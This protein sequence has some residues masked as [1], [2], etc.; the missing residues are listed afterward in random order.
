MRIARQRLLH[1]QGQAVHAAPHIGVA[2][3]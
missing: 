1:L 3:G 2:D